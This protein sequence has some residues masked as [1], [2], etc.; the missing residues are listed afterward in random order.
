MDIVEAAL[1]IDRNR[2][3]E[4]GLAD[5]EDRFWAGRACI[6]QEHVKMAPFCDDLCDDRMRARKVAD[7]SLGG[8]RTY[9]AR[10]DVARGRRHFRFQ[11]INEGDVEA[12]VGKRQCTGATDA[13][14]SAGDEGRSCHWP[15]LPQE[16]AWSRA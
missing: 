7:I 13:A 8:Q 5:L 2:P 4:F 10:L 9:T 14:R 15:G 16:A 12:G 11:E 3:V 1:Q 6:V